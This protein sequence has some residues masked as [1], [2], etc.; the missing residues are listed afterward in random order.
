MKNETK[1]Q[2][3][4]RCNLVGIEDKQLCAQTFIKEAKKTK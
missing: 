3:I 4:Q 2:F 1:K